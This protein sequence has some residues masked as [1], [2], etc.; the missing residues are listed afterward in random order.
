MRLPTL[1][2]FP[3]PWTH[4]DQF[5]NPAGTCPCDAF[6][7]NPTPGARVGAHIA[8]AKLVRKGEVRTIAGKATVAIPHDHQVR[9]EYSA[10]AVTLPNTAYYR[11]RVREADLIAADEATATVCGIKFVEPKKALEAARAAAT[12]EFDAQNGSGAFASLHPALV[13]Q[14]EAPSTPQPVPQPEAPTR[15]TSRKS[16]DT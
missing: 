12:S 9:W 1:R 7:H 2:V 13:P 8:E 16:D 15:K 11:E 10:D 5:G 6:E 4:I 3:N 14:P